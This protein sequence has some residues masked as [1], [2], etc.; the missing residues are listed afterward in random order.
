MKR[1]NS[2]TF[3]KIS[4]NISVLFTIFLGIENILFPY[5]NK[6]KIYKYIGNYYDF[7]NP[8]VLSIHRMF[9]VISGFVLI[10]I[11]YRLFKKMRM[12]W[13]I[14]LSVLSLSFFIHMLK[15][16]YTFKLTTIIE[17]I[18][19]IILVINYK[20]FKRASDPMSIKSGMMLSLIVTFF[21]FLN[22][23][24]TIYVLHI[25]MPTR[26]GINDAVTVTLKMIFLTDPSML[27][28]LSRIEIVF[29]RSSIAINWIGI[30]SV[31]I[32]ILK[33]LIYQP[34]VTTIDREKVRKLLKEYGDNPISYVS[35]ENDKKY[36]FGKEAEGTIAYVVAAGVAVCAGDPICSKENMP[37]LLV[38]FITYCRQNS[39]DICFCQTM[40]TYIPLY[41]QLGFGITKYGEEAMFDLKTYDLAG[42]KGAKIRNAV[43]HAAALGITISEYEP[44]KNRSKIIEQQINDI[45]EEWLGIKR[46]SELSFM[47]GTTSLENPM[48]RRYFAASD[49]HNRMLGYIVFSPFSG[50]KGYMADVTRRRNGAPIGVM[51]KITIE[52]FKK[53]KSEGVKWGSLGL[54]PLANV[55]ED[56]GVTGKMLELVYDRFNNF[57]GFKTLHHYK[58][59][60][61]PTA[62]EARYLVYYPRIFTP[63][64]AYSIIKA[65]NPKGVGDFILNQL[66]SIFIGKKDNELLLKYK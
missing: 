22:T 15:F 3:K 31:L 54:A 29:V 51:E 18:V 2:D 47:L 59:K 32:F 8:E 61:N 58:K 35:V 28:K 9:S 5:S 14:S 16:H 41:T 26:A 10:F 65:Q 30:I 46:S 38:E 1:V 36:Y 33:P 63:K 19:I 44:L 21:I 4:L 13:I 23:C 50:G 60:Y 6:I 62:W 25:K 56:G 39:F 57:Y 17:L 55:A 20:S 43:N 52:A 66:K 42:K 12:A 7:I 40:E 53:M 45:S 64:I 49:N 34:I 11:S 37:L 48:D 24:F 27:G